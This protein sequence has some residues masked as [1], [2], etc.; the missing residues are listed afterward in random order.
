MAVPTGKII[1]RPMLKRACGCVQEFQHYEV[2]KYRNQRQAKFQSTRCTECVNKLNE[3]QKRAAEA[4]PKKGEALQ[5]LP[6]GAKISL[7]RN[8][9]GKWAGTLQVGENT[10]EATGEGAP[11]LIVNLARRW[12]AKNDNKPAAKPK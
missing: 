11:G 4:M 3:E 2:D 7:M 12:A 10:L 1:A 8:A 6:A 5:A 9:D